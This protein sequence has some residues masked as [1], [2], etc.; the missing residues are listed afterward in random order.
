MLLVEGRRE[1]VQQG[2]SEQDGLGSLLD[3][4]NRAIDS[5]WRNKLHRR[6]GDDEGRH[7]RIQIQLHREVR[8]HAPSNQWKGIAVPTSSQNSA[9]RVRFRRAASAPGGLMTTEIRCS[10]CSS[11]LPTDDLPEQGIRGE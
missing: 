9:A 2:S 11:T 5:D 6:S 10:S 4:N 7:M 3:R 8:M 1:A